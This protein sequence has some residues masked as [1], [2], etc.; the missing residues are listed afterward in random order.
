MYAPRTTSPTLLENEVAK[1]WVA[2]TDENSRTER[3]ANSQKL[4]Q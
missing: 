2:V 3:A 4:K 1:M